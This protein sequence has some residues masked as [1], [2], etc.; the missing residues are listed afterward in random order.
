MLRDCSKAELL[1]RVAL[2]CQD[3]RLSHESVEGG[4]LIVITARVNEEMKAWSKLVTMRESDRF[5][6]IE[7]GILLTCAQDI[8]GTG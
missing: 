5:D 1:A 4:R 3:F 6:E 8:L 2:K 7:R